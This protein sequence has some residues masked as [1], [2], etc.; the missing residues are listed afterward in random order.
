MARQARVFSVAMPW[1]HAPSSG[2]CLGPWPLGAFTAGLGPLPDMEPECISGPAHTPRVSCFPGVAINTK[3]ACRG[4]IQ[5][6]PWPALVRACTCIPNNHHCPS[7]SA[8]SDSGQSGVLELLGQVQ[9][10]LGYDIHFRT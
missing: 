1:L 6:M 10:E 5:C 4:I 7:C 9:L 3:G 2:R 8:D